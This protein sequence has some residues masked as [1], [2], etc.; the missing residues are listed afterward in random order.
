MKLSYI[1]WSL[2]ILALLLCVPGVFYR[3]NSK[4]GGGAELLALFLL[5]WLATTVMS[6]IILFLSWKRIIKNKLEFI[7]TLLAIFNFC[8]GIYGIYMILA[9]Q[10]Y[11]PG[12]FALEIFILNLVWSALIFLHIVKSI[13]R[14]INE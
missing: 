6:P 13:S 1:F 2:L 5:L 10:V 9:G 3:N 12:P 11:R 8:F 7:F 14:S 4:L